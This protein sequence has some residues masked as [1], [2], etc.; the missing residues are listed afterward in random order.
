VIAAGILLGVLVDLSPLDP[1]KTLFWSAVV[2]G[3]IVVPIMVALMIVSSRSE[4][5]GK[6]VATRG[7]RVVG[8]GATGMMAVAAVAMFILM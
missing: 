1:I 8:W 7:Q 6:F 4:Q 2:N 5:M 3:V